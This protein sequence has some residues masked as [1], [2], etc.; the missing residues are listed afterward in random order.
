MVYN[1]RV[2]T[3]P[4]GLVHYFVHTKPV[5]TDYE[6]PPRDGPLDSDSVHSKSVS[7]SRS[8]V[9]V[10]DLALANS[11][12]YFLTGTFDPSRYDSS[13]YS[14][15][16]SC[17]HEFCRA[18]NYRDC[19]YLLVPEQH[20]SGVWHFHALISGGK[21]PLVPAVNPHTGEIIV[22]GSGRTVY[23]CDIYRYGFTTVTSVSDSDKASGYLAKYLTKAVS[24]PKGKK[25]YWASR[26]LSRPTLDKI[27]LNDVDNFVSILSKTSS[28]ST[29]TKTE[30]YGDFYFFEQ[31]ETPSA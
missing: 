15:F 11:W 29:V 30:N 10:Y 23:N 26:S 28:Y 6:R 9:S 12:D 19:K 17:V 14:V 7:K 13:D 21:L 22:D 24:V 3:F 1:C 8:K 5:P 27:V 2:K 4:S 25:R 16:V 18:L 20:Q 31:K